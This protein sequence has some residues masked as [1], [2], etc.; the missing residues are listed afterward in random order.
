[1]MGTGE[2]L[3]ETEMLAKVQSSLASRKP[4]R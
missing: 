2:M 4:P 3:E 1:V